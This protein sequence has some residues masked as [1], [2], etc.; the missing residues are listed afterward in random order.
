[1]R[2][3]LLALLRRLTRNPRTRARILEWVGTPGRGFLRNAPGAH[4]DFDWRRHAFRWK[5]RSFALSHGA[6]AGAQAGTAR[7]R[8]RSKP[9]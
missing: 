8:T 5:S 2:L 1:M 9:R 7:C 3:I 4:L 6:G